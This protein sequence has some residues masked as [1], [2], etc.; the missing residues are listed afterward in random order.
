[1]KKLK[2]KVL[3]CM[4]WLR[5][6]KHMRR[7]EPQW[8][9]KMITF[10]IL[11]QYVNIVD[12]HMGNMYQQCS[13]SPAPLIDPIPTQRFP[14]YVRDMLYGGEESKLKVEFSVRSPNMVMFSLHDSVL[15]IMMYE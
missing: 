15:Y 9:K 2:W 5:I 14:E 4:S 10:R 1:M 6:M 3:W 8:R 7:I 11:H 13:L 12:V